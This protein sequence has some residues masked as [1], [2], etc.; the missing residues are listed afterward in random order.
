MICQ[1]VT[2]DTL[3]LK[4]LS[5]VGKESVLI[6]A[7]VSSL[8]RLSFLWFICSAQFGNIKLKLMTNKISCKSG[9]NLINL[10]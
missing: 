3:N 10:Y 6:F 5:Q 9:E 2:C 8:I 4:K 7:S 1:H